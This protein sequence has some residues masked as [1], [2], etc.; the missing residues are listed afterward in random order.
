MNSMTPLLLITAGAVL[1]AWWN[2]LVKRSGSDDLLFVWCYSAVSVPLMAGA[3]LWWLARGGDI[4]AAWWAGVVSMVL[5]TTYGVM[6]QK[7]YAKADMSVVY[8]VSR[9]LAPVIVTL[10]S[11]LW[12][13]APSRWGW[14]GIILVIIGAWCMRGAGINGRSMGCGAGL[15]ALVATTTAAYTLWDAY[16]ASVLHVAVIPYMV[17]SSTA[18]VLLLS[19]VLWS[20]REELIPCLR[21]DGRK[22]LPIAVLAPL[23]Y[24]LVILAMRGGSPSMVSTSRSLSVAVGSLFAIVFLRE[25]PSRSGA[26]GIGL[27]CAGAVA[28][29]L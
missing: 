29:A 14:A 15:G 20:R 10:V 11:L 6:L 1:H 21:D 3:L 16:S 4:G 26:V 13:Q 17:L 2:Y 19:G 22:A 5:H 28:S 8:P 7:A 25:R 24:A 18:Q 12:A 27:I 23:S 9:G